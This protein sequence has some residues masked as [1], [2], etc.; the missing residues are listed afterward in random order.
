MPY[1]MPTVVRTAFANRGWVAQASELFF[2]GR[3][4]AS[5]PHL[6]LRLEGRGTVPVGGDIRA[7]VKMLAWS[8]GQQHAGGGGRLCIRV[9]DNNFVQANVSMVVQNADFLFQEVTR[10]RVNFDAIMAMANA[11][12]ELLDE[13]RW[14][15]DYFGA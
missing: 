4:G 1:N 7:A 8:D 5:H 9:G 10:S 13:L 6:H 14:I 3:G 12:R 15:W 11:N 2:D